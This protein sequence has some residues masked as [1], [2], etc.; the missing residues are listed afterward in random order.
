VAVRD[1]S[2]VKN[3]FFFL[4][5]KN[6]G[7]AAPQFFVS[8]GFSRARAFRHALLG[9]GELISFFFLSLSSVFGLRVSGFSF[10]WA[11]APSSV[12]GPRRDRNREAR[13]PQ[14]PKTKEDAR[15]RN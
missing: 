14:S 2:T 12:L 6:L 10:L 5:M 11:R 8:Q 15:A 13:I 7:F 4:I 9:G 3:T 1:Q